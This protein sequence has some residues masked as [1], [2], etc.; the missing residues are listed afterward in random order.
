MTLKELLKK[1]AAIRAN[2]EQE[3]KK[4]TEQKLEEE[5]KRKKVDKDSRPGKKPASR[6]YLV[7]DDPI[8]GTM[9]DNNEAP[10]EEDGPEVEP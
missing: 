6:A 4:K 10:E 8:N 3:A 7:V 1:N 5:G 2:R 9:D